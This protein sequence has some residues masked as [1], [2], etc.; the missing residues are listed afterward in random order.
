MS[1]SVR[2]VALAVVAV[3]VGASGGSSCGSSGSTGCSTSNGRSR[4]VRGVGVAVPVVIVVVIVLVVQLLII[5]AITIVVVVVVAVEAVVAATGE[6]RSNLCRAHWRAGPLGSPLYNFT[7]T[8]AFFRTQGN[9]KFPWVCLIKKSRTPNR[10][11]TTRRQAWAGVVAAVVALAMIVAW[12]NI[13]SR[14][15]RSPLCFKAIPV[16]L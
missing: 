16:K 10:C 11:T 1:S 3:A 14:S 15:G 6:S 7:P 2:V 9:C 5:L 13:D 4:W 12:S 8:T